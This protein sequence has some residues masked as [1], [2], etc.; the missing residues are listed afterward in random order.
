[1]E[2]EDSDVGRQ[3]DAPTPALRLGADL[4]RQPAW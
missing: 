3:D 4:A 1:M 2:H